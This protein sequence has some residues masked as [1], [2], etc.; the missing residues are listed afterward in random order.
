MCKI[1]VMSGITKETREAANK[2]ILKMADKMSDYRNKDGLGYAAITE[3]GKLFGERW[4][5]NDKAFQERPK[6]SEEHL[7]LAKDLEEL[8]ME[9]VEVSE[10]YNSFGK[11]EM[12]KIAGI[13]LHTRLATSG[14]EFY[15]THP[16]VDGNTSLIHNGVISNVDELVLKQ[17]TCD[18]EAILNAYTEYD[19]MNNPKAIQ[20]VAHR[21]RGYYACGVFSKDKKN[22]VIL[23]LFKSE[24]ASLYSGFIKELNT[25][26]FTTDYD[27]LASACRAVGL[28]LEGKYKV[29]HGRLFRFNP[30][31]GGVMTFERFEDKYLD[32]KSSKETSDSESSIEY[33]DNWYIDRK[34]NT[35]CRRNKSTIHSA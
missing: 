15:N 28:T 30:L 35:W 12:D 2:L 25:F 1:F 33:H 32:T 18:S 14:K 27:D 29:R 20:D 26:A 13:T 21:L 6:P 5:N 11:I 31:T 8:F 19:V 17:S 34:S 4:L 10:V 7:Q 22:R 3:E 9:S 16:F 23:D 24:G